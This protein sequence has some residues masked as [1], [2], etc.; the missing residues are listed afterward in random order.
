VENTANNT[1]AEADDVADG[2]PDKD[3]LDDVPDMPDIPDIPEK[4]D[5]NE[6]EAEWEATLTA[7][8]DSMAKVR[9][10]IPLMGAE[11]EEPT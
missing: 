5:D 3:D 10:P 8:E 7:A 2:G 9:R 1:D 6:K 4:E 11:D